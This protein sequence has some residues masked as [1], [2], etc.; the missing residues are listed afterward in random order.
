MFAVDQES[1]L[2]RRLIHAMQWSGLFHHNRE[3]RTF[4]GII[5]WWESR[6]FHYNV[7][8]L[9][10]GISS[11]YVYWHLFG[12]Y[13]QDPSDDGMFPGLLEISFG[14]MANVFYTFGWMIECLLLLVFRRRGLPF[15]GAPLFVTGLALSVLLA[16]V[17]GI[18]GIVNT[19]LMMRAHQQHWF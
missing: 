1:N 3:A 8:L 19:V 15:A 6:R 2:P 17:P 13:A 4:F 11:S 5:R 18:S 9:L 16:L 12:L 10:A 7:I 14:I